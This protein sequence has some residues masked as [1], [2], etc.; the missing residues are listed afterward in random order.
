LE[1]HDVRQAKM[2]ALDIHAVTNA[3]RHGKGEKSDDVGVV[4]CYLLLSEQEFEVALSQP[5]L[6]QILWRA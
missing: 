5:L 3:R 4:K 1:V 2:V 6:W